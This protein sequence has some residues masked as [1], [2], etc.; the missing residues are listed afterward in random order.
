MISVTQ[1]VVERSGS[2]KM[3]RSSKPM[4]I[5]TSERHRAVFNMFLSLNHAKRVAIKTIIQIFE[6]S[7]G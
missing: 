5:A 3:S 7:E 6:N 1:I 4:E 2:A